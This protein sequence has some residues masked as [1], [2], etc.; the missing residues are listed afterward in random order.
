MFVSVIVPTYNRAGTIRR[1]VD[2]VL[3]QTHTD[4]ELII[5]DDGSV[6]GT[7]D[8][9]KDYA[10][11]IRVIVQENAGPSAARNRGVA[12]SRGSIVAFLDSDDQWLPEKLSL[13]VELLTRGGVGV[14]CCVC[15]A[16]FNEKEKGPST[17]FELAGIKIG[18]CS[19]YLTN[20]EQIVATRFFIFNQVVAIWKDA[21]ERVGGFDSQLGIVEDWDLALKL[22]TLGP[23][24]IIG[25]ALVVKYDDTQG[26]GVTAMKD[27]IRHATALRHMLANFLAKDFSRN[28]DAKRFLSLE[29]GDLDFEIGALRLMSSKTATLVGIAKLR[30]AFLRCR[31]AVRRRV[32]SWPTASVHPSIGLPKPIATP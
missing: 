11:R 20:P 15:N 16:I 27:R 24:G 8:L 6:D 28:S 1:A 3:A 7:V 30:L 26:I 21:F 22:S 10:G 2:S 31:R 29:V 14:P 25:S 18:S 13:Q 17:S 19:G 23:W 4:R 9:L 32:P 12:E 5:V